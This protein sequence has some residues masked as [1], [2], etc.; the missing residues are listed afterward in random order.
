[1]IEELKGIVRN[2][3]TV[4]E[5]KEAAVLEIFRILISKGDYQ[6][7]GA[8]IISLRETWEDI[9]TPRITKIIRNLFEMIPYSSDNFGNV[10]ELLTV[11]VEWADKENKKML[12]LDLECKKIYALLKT[13]RY[14]EALAQIG[15]VAHE[16]KKYDDKINLI[17]LYV[18]ESKAFYEIKN[19]S[20]S[21]SSL[22]SARVLAVS[23]Y[24]PPQLQAQIDLLSGIYICDERN[25]GVA[26]SYFIEALEG[27]TLGKM[28][29]EACISLRYLILSKIMANKRE[30]INTVMKNKSTLKHLGDE[31]IRVLL[32]VSNSFA[33]RDLKSY[34]NVLQE[35]S[36]QIHSDSFICSHL[37]YLYDLLLDK[38]IIKI[39][40]PYSVIRISFIADVLGFGV[41]VIEKKLRKMIL[42]RA[43][44]GTLDH[45]D[46][47]LI[48]QGEKAD[49]SFADECMKQVKALNCIVS[50]RY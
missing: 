25:Y 36:E 23:A 14:S 43:V 32:K 50:P 33:N 9:T 2:K 7:I 6:E 1:M 4:L 49:E 38:N 26:S 28:D 11:L 39:I 27:F 24:C 17:T 37:Q 29:P 21:K 48:L 40:E 10:L 41:D 34:T 19:I 45:I 12:R 3:E 44:N 5:E 18:Y 20:K 35:Y 16:L 15:P 22:T 13:G 31:I 46:E 47:C 30:E 8:T 42:D